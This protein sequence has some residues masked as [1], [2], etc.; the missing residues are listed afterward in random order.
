MILCSVSLFETPVGDLRSVWDGLIFD[1][2]CICLLRN[3][4]KHPP[5][6]PPPHPL[7]PPVTSPRPQAKGLGIRLATPSPADAAAA[8]GVKYRSR[9]KGFR[10]G[11]KA[12]MAAITGESI[13]GSSSESSEQARRKA[14]LV[15]AAKLGIKTRGM[16][17]LRPAD[18]GGVGPAGRRVEGSRFS[19]GTRNSGVS[20]EQLAHGPD[21][22]AGGSTR[23]QKRPRPLRTGDAGDAAGFGIPQGLQ[24]DGVAGAATEGGFEVSG[25][26]AGDDRPA[27]REAEVG[28]T[29][30]S[31]RA[32]ALPSTKRRKRGSSSSKSRSKSSSKSSSAAISAAA[33]G[34]GGLAAIASLY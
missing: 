33:S 2:P 14:V 1:I 32:G 8:G 4:N 17:L 3:I 10:S 25:G 5:P 28:G 24:G 34:H 9:R 18:G 27:A 21:V 13:F 6:P 15:K 30:A 16:R 19:R 11:E 20:A 22:G 31:S 29:V 23:R 7:S 26:S 12:K